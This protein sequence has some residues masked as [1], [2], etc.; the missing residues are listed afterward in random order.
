MSHLA[1]RSIAT[2]IFLA[3]LA[4]PARG[5]APAATLAFHLAEEARRQGDHARAAE[6]LGEAVRLDPEAPLPRI[7][8]AAALLAVGDATGAERVLAPLDGWWSR[9]ESGPAGRYARLRAAVAARAHRTEEASVWYERA[10]ERAPRDLGLRAQLI[11]HYRARGDEDRALLHLRVVAEALPANAELQIELGR[12]L[13]AL[14]RW[15]EAELVFDRV[16]VFDPSLEQ[17][18][19]GLGVARTRRGDYSGAAEALRRGLQVAPSSAAIYEHLGDAL[20]GDGE[21]QGAVTAYERAAALAPQ[22]R[23]I[24]EKVDRARAALPR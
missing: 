24:A 2:A 7:E 8:W 11:G 18:W 23:R 20:L 17:A 9:A 14:Q 10:A 19:D 1:R 21:I 4:G 6:L 16:T 15:S 3:G 5:Q 22:E 13:L 12:A